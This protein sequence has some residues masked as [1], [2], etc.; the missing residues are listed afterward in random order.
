MPAIFSTKSSLLSTKA[1]RNRVRSAQRISRFWS[2]RESTPGRWQHHCAPSGF[3]FASPR[4]VGSC[5]RRSRWR[6]QHW[7]LWLTRLT[8]WQHS[9]CCHWGRTVCP[10]TLR[11]LRRSMTTSFKLTAYTRLPRSQRRPAILLSLP[12]CPAPYRLRASRSGSR[13]F[14]TEQRQGPISDAF[15]RKQALLTAPRRACVRPEDSTAIPFNPSSGG[16]PTKPNEGLTIGLTAR[17]GR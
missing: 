3:R 6:A 11:W 4:M 9:S 8:G 5:R 12:H 2:I 16:S 7:R 15:L 13:H 10:L 17:G 14:P 1:P